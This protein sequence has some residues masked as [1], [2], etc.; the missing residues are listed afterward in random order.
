ML[1]AVDMKHIFGAILFSVMVT[2]LAWLSSGS[3][4]LVLASV[5]ASAPAYLFLAFLFS[6]NFGR[7]R[8]DRSEPRLRYQVADVQKPP[9]R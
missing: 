8:P 4:V 2:A 1:R 3:L 6:S 5:V 7:E 9:L